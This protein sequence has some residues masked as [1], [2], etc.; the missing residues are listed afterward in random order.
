[1]RRRQ[2]SEEEELRARWE[3]NRKARERVLHSFV[4]I[5]KEAKAYA[6]ER[7]PAERPEHLR[8]VDFVC[9][10]ARLGGVWWDERFHNCV[11]AL[12]DHG[13]VE[14]TEDGRFRFTGKK[15]PNKRQIVD[16]KKQNDRDC[17][18]QVHAL[19]EQKNMSVRLASEEVAAATG[20]P[21][22]THSAASERLRKLYQKKFSKGPRPRS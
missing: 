1:M 13:I 8:A 4:W 21:G 14:Q 2:Q 15:E 11:Q 9:E 7:K 16:R 19:V 20:Y 17:V 10:L 6:V 3:R 12:F 22:K 18:A 5:K